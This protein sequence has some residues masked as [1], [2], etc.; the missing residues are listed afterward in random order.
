MEKKILF[1]G[2]GNMGSAIICAA[3]NAKILNPKNTFVI[4]HTPEKVK[5][6][7]DT[8]GVQMGNPEDCDTIFCAVKPQSLESVFPLQTAK[9]ALLISILAGKESAELQKVSG[10]LQIARVMPNTPALVHA[11]MSGIYFSDNVTE[12]NKVFTTSLFAACGEVIEIKN[13]EKMHAITALSGSGPAYFFQ[14]V[15]HLIFAGKKMGLSE[16]E[17]EILAKN[18]F[19]GAAELLK[20]SH[21][22]PE[23][24]R[25]KVTSKGGT[26]QAALE[27]FKEN[28][29]AKIV[30]KA[31]EAAQK[32]SKEL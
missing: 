6:L 14:F 11:G 30:E 28:N 13:E 1:V 23:E 27:N 29:F 22:S 10:L 31:L 3:I 8:L 12:E 20:T 25:K 24:L 17:A 9:N 21:A 32:R 16:K 18:T 4:D 7:H 5:N 2:A 26:T 15:E 19:Y